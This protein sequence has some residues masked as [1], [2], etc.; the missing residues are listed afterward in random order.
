[1]IEKYEK[2][3]LIVLSEGAK[4]VDLTAEELPPVLIEKSDGAVMYASSDMGTIIDRI[5]NYDPDLILYIVDY[6][7]GLHFKQVFSACKKLGILKDKNQVK[8][9][10]FGTMNGNDNKPF[11]T[12]SGDVVKLKD[13]IADVKNKIKEKSDNNADDALISKIAI[14]CIKFAD[15]I[16]FRE[17]N[18]VFD[19]E[20]FTSYEGKTGAYVLY[21]LARINSI[22]ENN[23][24]ENPKITVLK[25]DFERDILMELS[26]YNGVVQNAYDKQAPHFI[27]EYL[28]SICKL[29]S[30]FYGN[31][32]IANETDLQYKNSKISLL[33]LVK[34]HIEILLYLLG[35][36]KIQKM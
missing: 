23:S 4:I 35:I 8:H 11:K 2:Q 32:N 21:S 31:C 1:M 26:K 9:C 27:A 36:E 18:Y 25:S 22:L 14:A 10:P 19:L 34:K 17:A 33:Y 30:S 5:D 16:N 7:Q 6:R 24:L 15:L 13:L 20:N 3:G 28:Y 29:F 12:R